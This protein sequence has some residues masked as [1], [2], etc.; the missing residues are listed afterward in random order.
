MET[1]LN[2]KVVRWLIVIGYV[3]VQLHNAFQI[4]LNRLSKTR[5]SG[6]NMSG[7]SAKHIFT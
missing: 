2:N 7:V 4:P 6:L 3:L 5:L 1:L